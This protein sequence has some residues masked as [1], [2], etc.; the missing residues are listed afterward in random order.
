MSQQVVRLEIAPTPRHALRV[1][2]AIN[3]AVFFAWQAAA[4]AGPEALAWMEANF[5]VSPAHLMYGH[6][7]TLLSSTV[8]HLSTAHLL[9][10]LW[11]LWL[12]GRDVEDVVG[13]RGFTHLY[14]AGGIVA[15]LG[16]VLYSLVSGTEVPALG[17]SGAV[18]A[19]AV[20][21]AF[22]YPSRLL[23]LFF[24]IPITQLHAI[25]L[26]VLIDL[27]G[28][29]STVPDRIAHAAHLGGSA[30]GWLYYRY[31]VDAYFRERIRQEGIAAVFRR[32]VGRPWQD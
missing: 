12:F 8:S 9:F 13:A 6:V 26:F 2:T 1:L 29:F 10:N 18:M 4:D 24:F 14:V 3:V 16:H 5:L 23:L 11:A 15:S 20:V 32:S 21:A 7:W 25:G 30:Y 27:L 17:A 22:L 28:L 31:R 19:V